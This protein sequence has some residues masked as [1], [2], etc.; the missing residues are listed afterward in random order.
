MG[1]GGLMLLAIVTK[2]ACSA[3]D[4]LWLTP[5]MTGSRSQRLRNSLVY[6]ACVVSVTSVAGL[7]SLGASTALEEALADSTGW[8]AAKVLEL[9]G[10]SLLALY[11]LKLLRDDIQERAEA[12]EEAKEAKAQ[13]KPAVVGAEL[14][15]A[16][17]EA[18]A[19]SVV[20]VVEEVE[21]K[22]EPAPVG[23]AAIKQLIIICWVGSIDDLAVQASLLVAGTF[24][25]L[26]LYAGV[27][28]GSLLVI[29]VCLGATFVRPVVALV[30]KVP[31]FA[32]VGGLAVWSFV[33][34]LTGE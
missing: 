8:T 17:P 11:A 18:E 33:S 7:L 12:A 15:E 19:Q 32:I 21:E 2:L 29:G 24:S 23:W 6:L 4:V 16:Q 9:V 20:P 13:E 5:F 25:L 30:E 27:L 34:A 14:E 22:E 28:I 31:L 1:H 3:D 26:H 10:G